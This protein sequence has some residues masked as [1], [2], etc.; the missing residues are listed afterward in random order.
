MLLSAPKS[1]FDTG[2]HLNSVMRSF[3]YR[4]H[5]VGQFM[6]NLQDATFMGEATSSFSVDR[7][8][9]FRIIGMVV[10]ALY[11]KDNGIKL[12]SEV[13]VAWAP[14]GDANSGRMPYLEKLEYTERHFGDTPDRKNGEIFQYD[15][16]TS[17]DKTLNICRLK[18]YQGLPIYAIWQQL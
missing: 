16:K 6:P 17:P 7:D 8:R 11:F 15:W 2:E 5:L 3:Q 18:F 12:S 9:F 10:K 1:K 13:R 4:P 14:L